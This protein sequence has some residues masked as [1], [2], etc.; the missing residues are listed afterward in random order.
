MVTKRT[1]ITAVLLVF[2]L[3]VHLTVAPSHGA[4]QMRA[5]ARRV[6]THYVTAT[7]YN[8]VPEQTKADPWT[9]ASGEKLHV[10][11]RVIA[12]SRDLEEQ[13]MGFGTEV[14]IEGLPGTYVVSDRTAPRWKQ[15]ID[16]Y[17]GLDLS[18]ARGWG[19]RTVKIIWSRGTQMAANV[20]KREG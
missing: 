2:G 8:S 5:V 14:R 12:V 20:F 16:I 10:G 17:M 11:K 1:V 7:A 13:G 19:K 18:R 3:P 4:A 9:T 15:R 6:Q